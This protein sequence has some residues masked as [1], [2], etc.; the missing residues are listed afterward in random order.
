M[1]KEE[2]LQTLRRAL[3][4]TVPAQVVEE[5]MRYYQEY[6]DGEVRGGRSEEDVIAEIGDP[7]LIAKNIED[8]TVGDA[9]DGYGD[10]TDSGYADQGYGGS[11]TQQDDPYQEKRP[12]H[13]FDLSQWYGKAMV[14]LVVILVLYVVITIVGGIFTLLAPLI[15][16]LFVLWLIITIVNS[17]RRR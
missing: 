1:R 15:G 10:Y 16:P 2:F 17:I 4:G 14:F 8:T 12:F 7:R 6:I 11:Y 5:N 9:S 3:T 13:L